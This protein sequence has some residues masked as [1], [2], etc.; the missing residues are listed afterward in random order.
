[1]EELAAEREVGLAVAVGIEPVMT[2]PLEARRDRVQ[3]EAANKLVCLKRHRSLLL[4][5]GWAVVFVAEAHLAVAVAE[6]T[7]V[8][9]RYFVRVSSEIVDCFLWPAE[10]GFAVDD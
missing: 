3:Q 9:D 7:V 6:Q 1:M 2:D 8:G 10:G 5:I 4:W